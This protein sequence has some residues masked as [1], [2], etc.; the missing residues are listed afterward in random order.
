M[1]ANVVVN[2]TV[3]G[4]K[5][6]VG[7]FRDLDEKTRASGNR[8]VEFGDKVTG[9][10]V[11]MT[12]WATGAAAA[13][14]TALVAITT[15][16]VNYTSELQNMARVSNVSVETFQRQAFA[17]KTVGIENEKLADIF[18]DVT[19]RVGDFMTTGGGPMADFFETVAPKVGI[20]AEAFKDL[21]GPQALQLF[22]STMEAAGLSQQEMTFHMEAMASD[23]TLLIPLL[24]DNGAEMKNLGDQAERAGLILSTDMIGSVSDANPELIKMKEALRITGIQIGAELLPVMLKLSQFVLD[25]VIPVLRFVGNVIGILVEA[26]GD[27]PPPIQKAA[28]LIGL[29]L[30]VGGPILIAVGAMS[31]AFGLLLAST[32]PVGLF[33]AAAGIA[34]AAWITWGDEIKRILNVTGQFWGGIFF[35]MV[36]AVKDAHQAA[37]DKTV[38][39]ME[40]ISSAIETSATFFTDIFQGAVN[41]VSDLIQ[42]V[43]DLWQGAI[44][45]ITSILETGKEAIT[46]V[47]GGIA[48]GVTGAFEAMQNVLVGNS[49]IPDTVSAIQAEWE[50]LQAAL[51]KTTG[52]IVQATTDEFVDL[53]EAVTKSAETMRDNV[54]TATTEMAEAAGETTTGMKEVVSGAACEMETNV[55]ECVDKMDTGMRDVFG[56]LEIDI[57]PF[58]QSIG[59]KIGDIVGGWDWTAPGITIPI[60][61]SIGGLLGGTINIGGGG[62]DSGGGGGGGGIIIGVG[63]GNEGGGGIGGGL[64]GP[65][66]GGGGFG[67]PG[68][69]GQGWNPIEAI[70]EWLG[71]WWQSLPEEILDAL[72]L[73]NGGSFVTSQEQLIRVGEG[74]KSERV[75]VTPTGR[76]GASGEGVTII[77]QGNTILDDIS[78]NQ[79]ENRIADVVR[80]SM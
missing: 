57:P 55:M 39:A 7:G 14:T 8:F 75:T 77:F 53:E 50:K 59:D 16:T 58:M 72:G 13:A 22:V 5:N 3:R 74:G 26:I 61:F 12:K 62:S 45:S 60:D 54:E 48:D 4:F 17:A 66:G 43:V 34:V 35:D 65:I 15:K 70:A 28:K 33:I 69:G 78:M 32:G 64:G 63:G 79:L 71:D 46:G 56:G 76:R 47:A 29:A 37:V 51:N 40:A 19:D 67:I 23:A 10:G 31:K 18:K 68:V 42:G 36:T 24:A 9:A 80:R 73:A 38:Q 1:A 6:A 49:I 11:A 25:K 41:T 44:D 52:E 21:S 20:T 30:G 2:L 27:A